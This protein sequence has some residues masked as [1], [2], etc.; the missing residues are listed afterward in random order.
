MRAI[1]ATATRQFKSDEGPAVAKCLT[2]QAEPRLR[3]RLW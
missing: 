2:A 3:D 1:M